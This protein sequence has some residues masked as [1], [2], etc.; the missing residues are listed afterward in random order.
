[1]RRMGVFL[2]ILCISAISMRAMPTQQLV[3]KC[4]SLKVEDK[5]TLTESQLAGGAF[6]LGY[7]LGITDGG[8][9][10]RLTTVQTHGTDKTLVSCI[11]EN[12][13]ANELGLI[14]LKYMDDHPE[15]LHYDSA[16][17][18]QTA[19]NHSFPCKQ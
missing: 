17:N 4:K 1:M 5:N 18:V 14:F 19:I 12:V 6:C 3:D 10:S 11:P 15:Y 8:T 2:F 7:I 9:F 13:D 16:L